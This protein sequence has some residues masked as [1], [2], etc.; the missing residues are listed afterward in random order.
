M[1]IGSSEQK[2]VVGAKKSI[3]K[4]LASLFT[5]VWI[6]VVAVSLSHD[7]K[8]VNENVVKVA[9]YQA[10]AIFKKDQ[11]IRFW[12]S[13]HG[14]V[15]VEADERTPQNPYLA[16]IL[17]RD[18]TLESGKSLTLM[19]PA[20]MI[21]QM[22]EEF[23]ELY[24]V[25]GHITSLKPLRPEN[26]P[27]E[28]ERKA[29]LS[30]EEGKTV[31][32]E[33]ATID[34]KSYL[35][36]MQPMVT[37]EGCLKCHSHQG[38]KIGD[39]RGGVG[40]AVPLE[41]LYMIA[42]QQLRS[43]MIWHGTIFILG[44]VFICAGFFQLFRWNRD[45]EQAEKALRL[46]E[47]RFQ[48]IADYSYDWETW[49]SPDGNFEYVSPSCEIIS[50]YSRYDFL[51]NRDLFQE[52][53]HLEDREK[54]LAHRQVHL[55]PEYGKSELVCRIITKTG[56]TRWI[57]HKCQ[58]I[59][60][61]DG[62]WAG[63]RTS[64][65]DI[66]DLRQAE[67]ELRISEE[68]LN[69][70]LQNRELGLWDWNIETGSVLFNQCWAD[71]LGY[72]LD[73]IDSHIST[74]KALIHPGDA[75]LVARKLEEHFQGESNL[76][77]SEYRL[78]AKSGQWIWVLDK[79]KVVER[80]NT[81][82]P[83]RAIGTQLDITARRKRE[84]EDKEM[85]VK[86]EQMRRLQ[87]LE[88]MAAAIAHRFN[89]AMTAVQGNLE[90]MQLSLADDSA[91]KEMATRALSA[92]RGASR[93]GSMMLTYVG[94]GRP[95]YPSADLSLLA[96]KTV[97]DMESQFSDSVELVFS[98]WEEPLI[99][100]MDPQQ[101]KEVLSTVLVNSIEALEGA[102]GTI[103]VSFG[104]DSFRSSSFPIMFREDLP[105]T[106]SYAFCQITDNGVGIDPSEID[107]VFEP[108]FTTKFVGR[109]LGLAMAAGIMRSHR[110]ALTVS[111][112]HGEGT[113][114]RIL[115]P[116][117]AA[118]EKERERE[119]G[120]AEIV[121]SG[122]VLFADDDDNVLVAGKNILEELGFTVVTA[123]NGED[124]VSKAFHH[125]KDLRAIVLDV[126][127]PKKDGVEA[128]NEIRKEYAD[129]PVL[130]VSGYSEKDLS[131]DNIDVNKAQ[132][133]L[134]KPFKISELKGCLQKILA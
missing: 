64:N 121:Y 18:I 77:E 116:A 65:R 118:S 111:S 5:L 56:Q 100:A 58:P 11:A 61:K 133:F 78:L 85:I 1:M 81:G 24:G 122:T 55:D 53:V 105:G 59:F 50:G 34:G 125:G 72:N 57:W 103:E 10:E 42:D 132:G 30:F 26:A 80:D 131:Q 99:C 4:L 12:G 48:A 79:G 47:E 19:N 62:S 106:S 128:M 63:R 74:W 134:K 87:S 94:Q 38:Y 23:S 27:D 37:K 104:V 54:F 35:R 89:N 102:K 120:K 21:R 44:V 43:L 92:A 73:E 3:F 84:S 20:Y 71:M 25:V 2:K 119:E 36:F 112:Q 69:L 115:L 17:D 29:L 52:I 127:M 124:A 13:R 14:G 96:Q 6:V 90:L 60:T 88:V 8:L 93:V 101:I 32:S 75:A 123:V 9:Q 91:E 82:K 31:Q 66:T 76:Y 68:R 49:I 83:I 7:L 39:I 15:Y 41:P 108:F 109:G 95:I 113:I 97:I 28:W 110:G 86:R 22:N 51:N 129:I 107:R 98:P 33:V 46:S 130:L 16:H 70:A 40:V 126:S 117:A 67:N 45:R 114:V